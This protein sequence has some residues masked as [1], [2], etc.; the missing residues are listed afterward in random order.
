MRQSQ[1]TDVGCTTLEIPSRRA[2]DSV[3]FGAWHS[4][5]HRSIFQHKG[6]DQSKRYNSLSINAPGYISV[7]SLQFQPCSQFQIMHTPSLLLPERQHLLRLPMLQFSVV[8]LG[9]CASHDS[10]RIR[11]T[12]VPA[13]R[14]TQL[15]NRVAPSCNSSHLVLRNVSFSTSI[16]EL[17]L[18]SP[19]MV[20]RS[21][22]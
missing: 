20:L 9:G 18:F 6:S 14:F 8:A 13:L 4:P 12:I 16:S 11:Q 17:F 7:Q 21:S 1:G 5:N 10:R 3:R 19:F 15:F 2:S 22:G